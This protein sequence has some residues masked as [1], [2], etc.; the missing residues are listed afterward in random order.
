MN[1]PIGEV[2]AQH[3]PF[4]ESEPF[5]KIAELMKSGFNG[6]IVATAEGVSGL[7]EGLLMI[8]DAAIIGAV[9]DAL[10]VNKQ[11]HGVSALR[12]VLNL[13][14]AKKGVYDLNKLSKQ[15][16]DLIMAFNEKIKLLKIVDAA[17]LSKLQPKAY[18]AEIVSK[19]LVIEAGPAES[20]SNILKKFGL[21]SI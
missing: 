13:L 9:F 18:N 14:K 17:I 10:R 7:E 20:K 15:Q 21:G 3:I 11:F 5:S 12:L 1:I 19:E 8:R 4:S 2:E 16:I 6:Y